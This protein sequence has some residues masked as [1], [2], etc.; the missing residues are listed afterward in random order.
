MGTRVLANTGMG[1]ADGEC[2]SDEGL[3]ETVFHQFKVCKHL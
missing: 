2:F 3:T 1:V